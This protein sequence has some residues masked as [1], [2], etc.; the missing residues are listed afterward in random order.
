[1]TIIERLDRA[2]H[3]RI[4]FSCGKES[5][6]RFLHETA[7]QAFKKNL[8]ATFVAVNP[9]FPGRILGYYSVCNFQ[10]DAQELP[11]LVRRRYRLPRHLVPATLIARLAVDL[12]VQGQGIGGYLLLDA[13]IRCFQAGL[14][15]ASAA[16]IVDALEEA[17]VPFY[18]QYGFQRYAPDS[19]KHFIMMDTVAQLELVQKKISF[20]LEEAV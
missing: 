1:M 19:L 6:D 18:E 4:A 5:L 9:E 17:I 7:H 12:T 2:T 16:I 11:D 15:V 8:A 14:E 10:I 3:N 13:L 20:L